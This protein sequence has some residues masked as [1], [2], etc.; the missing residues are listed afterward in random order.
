VSVFHRL[1]TNHRRVEPKGENMS[2]NAVSCTRALSSIRDGTTD[3]ADGRIMCR[4]DGL[5]R[6]YDHRVNFSVSCGRRRRLRARM[7]LFR[8]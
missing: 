8:A 5:E 2:A 4:V 6:S 7:L 1:V 3:D